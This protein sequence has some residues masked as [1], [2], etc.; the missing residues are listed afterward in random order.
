VVLS[1][2]AEDATSGVASVVG[3][4]DGALVES[5]R[6]V[7]LYQLP[8]GMHGFAVTATDVAGNVTS[9]SLTFAT[10]TSLRDIAQLLDRFRA[11]NRL[12]LSAYTTLSAQLAKARKAEANG[13]DAKAVRELGKFLTMVGDGR[14]TDADV[15]A[16]SE[17]DSRAVIDSI[18]G[19]EVLPQAVNAR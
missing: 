8:L 3:A 14:V 10:T 5:G 16:T 7:A 6:A 1:W 11:T 13:N 18:N 9:Q 4:V 2:H 17:R 12:S 15:R 19:V